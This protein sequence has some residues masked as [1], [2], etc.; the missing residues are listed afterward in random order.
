MT[1]PLTIEMDL[2]F[3]TPAFLGDAMQQAELRPQSFKGGLRFWYRAIDAQLAKPD[4][5]VGND[6]RKPHNKAREDTIWGGA[7][8]NF[9]Q[10]KVLLRIP[11]SKRPSLWK[12]DRHQFDR[13]TP[14]RGRNT[15]NGVLYLGYPFGLKGNQKRNALVQGTSFKLQAVIPRSGSLKEWEIHAII[16][17]LWIFSVLGS[18][19]TRSR[20]GFGSLQATNWRLLNPNG[21]RD[22]EEAFEALPMPSEMNQPDRWK[23]GIQKACG[24][25]RDWFGRFPSNTAHPHIYEDFAPKI[26]DGFPSWEEAL[27]HA[28]SKMQAFRHRYQPD[29]DLVM[30]LLQRPAHGKTSPGRVTFGLPLT[31]RFGSRSSL[32]NV[33]F[34]PQGLHPAYKAPERFASLLFLKVVMFDRYY[35]PVF[36]RLGGELPG[37]DIPMRCYKRNH[38]KMELNMALPSRENN[39]M[40]IFFDS[41]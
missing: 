5:D 23:D 32:G 10:S 31:F 4:D 8:D 29:Y 21:N 7:G 37:F 15:R 26:L 1:T 27:N 41:L 38:N 11:N 19:G 24:Q 25:F 20:R 14:G 36:F 9:G 39:A 33:T 28:G 40:K 35:Y 16:A 12:W 6:N 2:V 17:S 13:F 3:T 30:D 18:C 22:W 34:Y